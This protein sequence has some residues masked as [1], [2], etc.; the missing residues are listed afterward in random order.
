MS[1]GKRYFS[2]QALPGGECTV[3]GDK[4]CVAVMVRQNEPGKKEPTVHDRLLLCGYD[5]A[6][7]AE[8]I[9]GIV[10]REALKRIFGSGGNR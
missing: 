4:K 6:V 2:I 5:L 9:D 1:E 8:R 7:L 10:R 3:C